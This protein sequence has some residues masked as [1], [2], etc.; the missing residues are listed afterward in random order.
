MPVLCLIL[1]TILPACS[2]LLGQKA[3]PNV[4]LTELSG[5]VA[6]TA[7][8]RAQ[9]SGGSGGNLETAV[10]D[11]TRQSLAF[12]ATQTAFAGSHSASLSATQTVAAPVVAELPRYGV[13]PAKGYAAWLHKPVTIE[14]SKYGEYG[15]ANDYMQVTASDFV[16][17]ADVNW[18][19]QYGTSGCGFMFRSNADKNKP[20]QYIVLMSRIG[21]GYL[22]FTAV[23]GGQPANIH[24]VYP[25]DNDKTFQW[26]NGTTNRLAVV[27][28]GDIIEIFT[29]GVLV[30]RIDTTQPPPTLRLPPA[31]AIPFDTSDLA[32]MSAYNDQVAEHEKVVQ[33]LKNTYDQSVSNYYKAKAVFREGFLA[34]IA[35]SE[36]GKTVCNFNNA[37]LWMIT[38][39]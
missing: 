9:S 31:P 32:A 23:D 16:L 35:A 22:A 10:A 13:D 21:T 18:D 28:R 39:E 5:S 25:K 33:R 36:S 15:Y 1:A 29:N 2:S 14:V 12:S 24:V 37:W 11:A 4:R 8:A 19:T 6:G 27:A 30:E 26:E 3:T 34:M 38:G 20:D 7:T 17:A